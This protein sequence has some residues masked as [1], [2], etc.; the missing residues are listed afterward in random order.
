MKEGSGNFSS[1]GVETKEATGSGEITEGGV[2][3]GIGS[4]GGKGRRRVARVNL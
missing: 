3:E 2:R 4:P 1:K